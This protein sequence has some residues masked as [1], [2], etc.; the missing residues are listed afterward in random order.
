VRTP[1]KLIS[2]LTSAPHNISQSAL[3]LLLT[4]VQGSSTDQSALTSL[5]KF[6]PTLVISS[7]GAAPIF[8]ASIRS[9]MIVDQPT[10][11]TDS[12]QTLLD[13]LHTEGENGS[14]LPRLHVV[15]MTAIGLSKKHRD[16]PF[17][18]RPMYSYLLPVPHRDKR[19]LEQLGVNELNKA[20]GVLAGFTSIKAPLLTD[21][22]EKGMSK[23]KV[24]WKYAEAQ[25]GVE[26]EPKNAVG[27]SI[28]KADV[29]RWLFETLVNG[30]DSQNWSGKSVTITY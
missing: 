12:M 15:S 2:L 5:L 16:M 17:L 13:A 29:G 28:S 27:Y 25:N 10:I 6:G 20:G 24:A 4:I 22:K 3:D 1:S 11:C 19:N 18:L 8:Q 9:P 30:K 14:P 21:G 26:K 23:I 7:V